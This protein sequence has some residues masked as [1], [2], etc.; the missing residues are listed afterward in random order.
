MNLAEVRDQAFENK[1][2]V[3]RGGNPLAEGRK[4]RKP[5]L[6]E[7]VNEFVRLNRGS[8]R[9]LE[10]AEKEWKSPFENHIYPRLGERKIGDITTPNLLRIF[11]AMWTERHDTA[12]R[13]LQ[14][15]NAVLEWAEAA[16][17]I[18]DNPAASIRRILPKSPVTVK[19]H[20]TSH[21]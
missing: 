17:R 7:S 6:R 14:R 3:V 8:W 13:L 1:R 21:C 18:T 4:P 15:T 10:K 9:H 11:G 2:Q 16:G 12:R 19:H 5:T 20:Q